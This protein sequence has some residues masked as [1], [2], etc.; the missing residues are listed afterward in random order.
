M[1][2]Y[3][4]FIFSLNTHNLPLPQ[5]VLLLLVQE[6]IILLLEIKELMRTPIYFT[7]SECSVTELI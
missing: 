3:L 6:A 7:F 2:S 5:S 4:S 1:Q